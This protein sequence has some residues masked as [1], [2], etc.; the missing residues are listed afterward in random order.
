MDS[1]ARRW[2]ATGKSRIISGP[3]AIHT[4][5]AAEMPTP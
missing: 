1:V 2:N 3:V 4:L 5:F